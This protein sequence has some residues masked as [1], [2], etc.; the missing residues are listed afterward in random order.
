MKLRSSPLSKSE[1][2]LVEQFERYLRFYYSD[3]HYE[4]VDRR[5]KDY[6][7]KK[8]IHGYK[9]PI[10]ICTEYLHPTMNRSD[11]KCKW[12][13]LDYF[14]QND[15]LFILLLKQKGLY[16]KTKKMCLKYIFDEHNS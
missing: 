15:Y 11:T 12:I 7:T 1:V 5:I 4:I 3:G 6:I 9:N 14:I 2:L 8:S 10:L 13:N 16:E